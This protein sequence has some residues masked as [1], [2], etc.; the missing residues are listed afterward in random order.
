MSIFVFTLVITILLPMILRKCNVDNKQKKIYLYIIFGILIIISGLRAVS[1]GIDSNSYFNEFLGFKYTNLSD[2]IQN[3]PMDIGYIIYSYIVYI[4]IGNIQ[5]IFLISSIL[6]SIGFGYWMYKY[7]EHIVISMLLYI[8][9]IFPVTMN[10]MRQ[11]IAM[12]FILLAISM[13]HSKNLRKAII[14]EIIAICFHMSAAIFIPVLF[15]SKRRTKIGKSIL[16]LGTLAGIIG[17]ALGPKLIEI[18][19]QI[20]PRYAQLLLY[21]N[22]TRGEDVS[23]ILLIAYGV[24]GLVTFIFIIIEK[25]TQDSEIEI[26]SYAMFICF[27]V[28]YY[29]S[30][31][32]V[33]VQR[34]KYYFIASL[35]ILVPFVL[36]KFLNTSKVGSRCIYFVI[37]CGLIGIGIYFYKQDGQG[38]LPFLFYWQE[39]VI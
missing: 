27:F 9:L 17:I 35:L 25:K 1:V 33:I 29:L 4:I 2:I 7:S 3:S 24:L 32:I 6:I 14:F 19:V 10:I 12:A 26:I 22:F 15:F 13:V 18:F 20:F 37:E 36:G 28:C 5:G 39:G 34:I 21:S 16:F 8:V 23:T 38:L 31:S 11:S 30:K